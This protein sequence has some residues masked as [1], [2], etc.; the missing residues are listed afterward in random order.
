MF[1]V[2]GLGNPGSKYAGHRHNVGFMAV[3][4]FCARQGAGPYR[5]KFKG[6]FT[7]H[8][9]SGGEVVILKPMTFMNLSGSSVQAAMRFFKIPLGQV[10]VVHDELDLPFRTVRLKWAGGIAGHNGLRSIVEHC[11][12]PEFTR[13]RVGIG[14]PQT[15][16][17]AQH[18][19]SDF[20]IEERAELQ[21][22]LERASTA[23]EDV[24]ELGI[25]SAMNRH[26]A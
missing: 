10:V 4:R 6:Q 15:G 20:S 7:R 23:L 13:L 21:D 26:N 24:L 12:G 18:V 22:V 17:P 11:G 16:T 1:L 5:E 19:L 2:V 8:S 14:R 25:S 3:D 9:L